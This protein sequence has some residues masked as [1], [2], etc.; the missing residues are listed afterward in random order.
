M[1]LFKSSEGFLGLPK[2]IV[3][4]NKVYK[5][6]PQE[7]SDNYDRIELANKNSIKIDN[8]NMNLLI[9]SVIKTLHE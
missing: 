7:L 4:K 2:E 8:F 9:Q 6:P 5:S 1:K 3:C